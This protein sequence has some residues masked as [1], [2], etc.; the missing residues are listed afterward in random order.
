VQY[1]KQEIESKEKWVDS[2]KKPFKSSFGTATTNSDKNFIKNYVTASPSNPPML[3]QF[4]GDK[5]DNWVY[6]PF[7]F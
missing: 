3:Y 7:K 6:G 1:R 4:R 5:K 2:E